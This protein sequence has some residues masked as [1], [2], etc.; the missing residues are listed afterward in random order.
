MTAIASAVFATL[1][2]LVFAL[3]LVRQYGQR[4]RSHALAWAVS[5]GWFA[6]G[7]G[8]VAVGLVTGWSTPIFL[9]YWLAGALLTVPF[10]AAG[11]LMLMDPKRT[12]LYWTLVGLV[13]VWALSALPLS[14]ID[15]EALRAA[16]ATTNVPVGHD[17]LGES[18]AYRLLGWFNYTAIIV[19]LGTIWSAVRT[20]RW[21][22]LLISVG[23]VIAGS[24]FAFIRT[25]Q[26]TWFSL[27]LAAGVAIM[28]VGFVAAGKPSKRASSAA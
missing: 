21:L 22:I 14:T 1:V 8:A 25:G 24:S 28:Y 18:L 7:S 17:V 11:Q 9:A 3:R 10:L 4:R 13:S 20:R 5:L 27:A 2:A 23:V 16:T 26:P 6:V 12:V 19:V 15:H